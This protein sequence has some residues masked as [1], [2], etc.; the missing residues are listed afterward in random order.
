MASTSQLNTLIS[1]AEKKTDD[2]AKMLG[3]AIRAGE[4][5]EQKLALLQQY[6]DDYAA[7]FESTRSVGLSIM[8]HQNYQVFL[9]KLDS[10]IIGQ[11]ITVEHE[12][13]HI[14]ESR[15]AWQEN[16]HK[17]MSFGALSQR[18]QEEAQR[19]EGKRDQKLMDEHAARL[20]AYKR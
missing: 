15:S 18:A 11:E 20:K 1:L 14:A 7:R 6:R 12:K 4:E 19:L 13:R 17:K 5:A 2:A 9:G 3:I 8:S 10:A 16:A